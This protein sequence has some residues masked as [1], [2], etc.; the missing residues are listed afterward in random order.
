MGK[1][2]VAY[3]KDRVAVY[4]NVFSLEVIARVC[5]KKSTRME[6]R[7]VKMKDVINDRFNVFCKKK[8]PVMASPICKIPFVRRSVV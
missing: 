4:V 2:S 1:R 3:A 8:M 6:N 5:A 7:T